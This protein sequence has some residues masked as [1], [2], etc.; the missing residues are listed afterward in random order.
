ITRRTRKGRVKWNITERR[1]RKALVETAYYDV[2]YVVA[3][4]YFHESFPTEEEAISKQARFYRLLD[5]GIDWVGVAP[6][7]VEQIRV[8]LL[9]CEI[10]EML[11]TSL[12]ENE[13][14]TFMQ[15]DTEDWRVATVQI[16]AQQAIGFNDVLEDELTRPMVEGFIVNIDRDW[17][18]RS[19]EGN[20]VHLSHEAGHIALD[21]SG[22]IDL[23]KVEE[24]HDTIKESDDPIAEVL[25]QRLF[26][27]QVVLYQLE[28]GWLRA[29]SDYIQHGVELAK[30]VGDSK[31][32]ECVPE[33]EYAQIYISA[34]LVFEHKMLCMLSE[35]RNPLASVM[36]LDT[37]AVFVI[38]GMIDAYI[39]PLTKNN[40]WLNLEKFWL[41]YRNF[42]KRL[43][44]EFL[45]KR[46]GRNRDN[47]EDE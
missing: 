10:F 8:L 30:A 37:Y 34:H 24:L 21:R 27:Y 25:F 19:F 39:T 9:D 11:D 32:G 42:M 15:A 3:Q 29:A 20:R 44:D 26:D 7:E 6:N 16:T 33:L 36:G 2:D 22:K 14:V 23:D 43:N 17:L 4:I 28:K 1:F 31:A 13:R 46:T 38:H 18:K 40:A 5:D 12:F 41:H 45:E 47:E 35:L